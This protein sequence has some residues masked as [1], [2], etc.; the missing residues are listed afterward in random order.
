MVVGGG[1]RGG[2]Q[3]P[4][5]AGAEAARR[6]DAQALMGSRA[7]GGAERFAAVAS[8][9]QTGKMQVAGLHELGARVMSGRTDPFGFGAGPPR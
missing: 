2:P 5:R 9:V 8:V 1:G 4:R 3:Q 6:E 7:L